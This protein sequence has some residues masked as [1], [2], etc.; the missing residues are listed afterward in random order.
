MEIS[1]LTFK[2]IVLLTPGVLAAI[3]YRRLTISHKPLPDFMFFISAIIQGLFSYMVLQMIIIIYH[4]FDTCCFSDFHYPT[5]HF[6]RNSPMNDMIPYKEVFAASC[7]GITLGFAMSAFENSSIL[8]R[9]A[10][11]FDVSKKYGDD[12]LFTRFLGLDEIEWIFVRDIK[13]GLTYKGWVRFH[14]ENEDCKELVLYDVSVY[15]YKDSEKLYEINSIYLCL[16]ID[17]IIIEDAQ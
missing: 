17:S 9:L 11:I 10:R 8:F 3:I 1:A 5:L 14:S 16:P 2:I 12:N 13:N 7:I 6:F 15:N 4:F